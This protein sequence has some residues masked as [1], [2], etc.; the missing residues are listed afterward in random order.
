[1]NQITT[2]SICLILSLVVFGAMC[3]LCILCTLIIIFGCD[4]Y[5]QRRKY[6]TDFETIGMEFFETFIFDNSYNVDLP[7]IEVCKKTLSMKAVGMPMSAD[8]NL[9]RMRFNRAIDLL[10][11]CN[12]IESGDV[13]KLYAEA[14]KESK[15]NLGVEGDVSKEQQ[16]SSTAPVGML[17]D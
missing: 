5:K 10:V 7:L 8:Q 16:E 17:Q 4:D 14:F 1:M 2:K 13:P 3:G 6:V 12:V 9:E 11:I 15:V